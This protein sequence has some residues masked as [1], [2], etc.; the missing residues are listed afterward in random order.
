[1]HGEDMTLAELGDLLNNT[2]APS[3]EKL[4][5]L[6]LAR[7]G[8]TRSPTGSL[9]HDAN[10]I[11]VSG[12]EG[13]YDGGEMPVAEAKQRLDAAGLAYLIYTSPS[14]ALLKPRWRVLL[15]FSHELPP[16]RRSKMVDRLNGVLGGVLSRESWSLS[17]AFFYG[18]I[19]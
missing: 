18:R 1:M 6:K 11:S 16:G 3:K 13:D 19:V 15:P 4:P 9:R 7:F 17:Q 5:L 12:A 2:V 14:H 8:T 10:V